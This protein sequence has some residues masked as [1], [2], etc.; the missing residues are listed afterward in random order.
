MSKHIQTA[1]LIAY[2]AI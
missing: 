1:D 2:R